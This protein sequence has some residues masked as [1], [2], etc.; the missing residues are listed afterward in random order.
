MAET[1]ANL[2]IMQGKDAA[3]AREQL[4]ETWGASTPQVLESTIKDLIESGRRKISRVTS[5]GSAG[6]AEDNDLRVNADGTITESTKEEKK[7]YTM[8]D[9]EEQMT[10]T[11]SRGL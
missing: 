3:E 11:M 6:Q 10:K 4:V 2:R 7:T 5:P 8:A 1:V 9:L